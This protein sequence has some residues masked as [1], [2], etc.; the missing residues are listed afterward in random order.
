MG[1]PDDLR[2]GHQPMIFGNLIQRGYQ[3]GHQLGFGQLLG[4]RIAEI[5]SR[6][7]TAVVGMLAIASR[8]F[9]FSGVRYGLPGGL[10]RYRDE[11]NGEH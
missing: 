10:R 4:T 1:Y 5:F 11:W 7:D 8:R 9:H 3:R 6:C 2:Q